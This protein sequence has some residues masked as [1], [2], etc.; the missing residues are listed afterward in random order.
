MVDQIWGI[1]HCIF[2]FLFYII[3]SRK[4]NTIS[5]P[6]ICYKEPSLIVHFYVMRLLLE[7]FPWEVS[8]QGQGHKGGTLPQTPWTSLWPWQYSQTLKLCKTSLCKGAKL[9]LQSEDF[10]DHYLSTPGHGIHELFLYY[11]ICPCFNHRSLPFL[12]PCKHWDLLSAAE[13][14]SH[15]SFHPNSILCL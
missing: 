14:G 4:P 9:S 5:N 12:Q 6:R 11:P 7:R 3:S 1:N 8:V 13:P 2:G 10:T 15:W